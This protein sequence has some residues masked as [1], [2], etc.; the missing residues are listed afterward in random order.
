MANNFKN[1]GNSEMNHM[2]TLGSMCFSVLLVTRPLFI[3]TCLFLF[4]CFQIVVFCHVQLAAVME[5]PTD[6]STTQRRRSV[7]SL[8][9]V[10]ALAMTISL[11][12]LMSVRNSVSSHTL[13]AGFSKWKTY[14]GDKC[15]YDL[16][17]ICFICLVRRTRN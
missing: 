4:F 10:A 14:I 12:L 16:V 7:R 6:I 5:L 17:Q 15:F 11:I 13:Q 3:H 9:M 8:S 1:Q 2:E